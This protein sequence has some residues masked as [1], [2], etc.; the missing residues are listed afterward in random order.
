MQKTRVQKQNMNHLSSLFMSLDFL[1]ANLA[2]IADL[3]RYDYTLISKLE[4]KYYAMIRQPR[5]RNG[6]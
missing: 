2:Y 3:E 5:C 6:G 1:R 4:E